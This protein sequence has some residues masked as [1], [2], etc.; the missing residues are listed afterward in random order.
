M[1]YG[2][3]SETPDSDNSS[4]DDDDD[5]DSDDERFKTDNSEETEDDQ[6]EAPPSFKRNPDDLRMYDTFFPEL[7]DIEVGLV[8]IRKIIFIFYSIK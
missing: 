8:L 7:F 4:L 3:A 6:G 1:G 2:S 5:I